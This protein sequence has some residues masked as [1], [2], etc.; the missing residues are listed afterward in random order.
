[1]RNHWRQW[2]WFCRCWGWKDH[3]RWSSRHLLFDFV[4]MQQKN[5]NYFSLTFLLLRMCCNIV[6]NSREYDCFKCHFTNF[7]ATFS[8]FFN[9]TFALSFS[10][11]TTRRMCVPIKLTRHVC[12]W[13][14]IRW[15]TAWKL[16]SSTMLLH[17]NW[18][19]ILF[20]SFDW[21]LC[22]IFLFFL[23]LIR[24]LR[25]HVIDWDSVSR[26]LVPSRA[27]GNILCRNFSWTHTGGALHCRIVSI[28][29]WQIKTDIFLQFLVSFLLCRL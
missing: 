6:S 27:G 15:T 7:L 22:C 20:F 14:G 3:W 19:F 23:G 18:T 24:P 10:H 13:S 4:W 29:C 28:V 8:S 16:F 12:D 9:I 21:T 26:L 17:S 2:C 11:E 25:R 5:R 1:M